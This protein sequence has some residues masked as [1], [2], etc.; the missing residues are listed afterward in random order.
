[1]WYR[2]E[3]DFSIGIPRIEFYQLAFY[4]M[5]NGGGCFDESRFPPD[6]IEEVIPFVETIE[7]EGRSDRSR[8]F[9]YFNNG[10]QYELKLVKLNNN[11]RYSNFDD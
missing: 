11:C 6:A 3:D 9:V 2:F 4:D 7:D 1:M 5:E 10:D 8:V